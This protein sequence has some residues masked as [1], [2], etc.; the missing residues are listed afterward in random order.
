MRLR[1][2]FSVTLESLRRNALRSS[3]TGLGVMVGTA[4]VIATLSVLFGFRL[5]VRRQMDALGAGYVVVLA[6]RPIP[7]AG[8]SPVPGK[9]TRDD[10]QA[11]AER[12][13]GIQRSSPALGDSAVVRFGDKS[14][15]VPIV[16][17]GPDWPE[18]RGQPVAR[19]RFFS[20][21]E[22]EQRRR[23][24]VLGAHTARDLALGAEPIGAEIL[25]ASMP[26]TVVGLLEEKGNSLGRDADDVVL[27]PFDTLAKVLGSNAE[28]SI[29]IH[30]KADGAPAARRLRE[31]I[32]PILRR[33]HRLEPDQPDDFKI[34]L[35]D[36]TAR[37]I[38]RLM[39]WAGYLIVCVLGISLFV[40]GIGV[41]NIMLISVTERTAEIGIRRALGA[42]RQDLRWQFLL[43][44]GTLS[45]GGGAAGIVIGYAA[46]SI[47]TRLVPN[48][49]PHAHLP[50]SIV[51][52][53]F[54]FNAAVGIL[55]GAYPAER[56]SRLSPITALR[57]E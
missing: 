44:S 37:G 54:L 25:V 2:L 48:S 40:A 13:E 5:G 29:E 7:D 52:T 26:V 35:Q 10:L 18:L 11:L 55:F 33:R 24:A 43:E 56:A 21:I 34:L 46:A 51:V 23:I 30:L 20:Q 14:R 41:L 4:S 1:D 8:A 42:R 16:G 28:S 9:L 53:A 6:D 45:A 49:L 27:V 57:Y 12:L 32:G 47:L 50:L 31:D 39:G 19:G 15:V 38:D 22:M 17:V 3:L 36:E